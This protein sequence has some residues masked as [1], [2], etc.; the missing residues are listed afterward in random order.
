[1]SDESLLVCDSESIEDFFVRCLYI[2]D[3]KLHLLISSFE[4][5]QNAHIF[6]NNFDDDLQLLNMLASF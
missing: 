6:S 3:T 4:I 1:M 2:L 5:K